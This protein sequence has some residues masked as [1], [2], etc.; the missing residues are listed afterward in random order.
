MIR[1]GRFPVWVRI[2][3]GKN[4]QYLLSV[5]S[6]PQT[7]LY[8]MLPEGLANEVNIRWIVFG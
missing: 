2:G 7:A 3:A 5:A 1:A 8:G 4:P 6:H